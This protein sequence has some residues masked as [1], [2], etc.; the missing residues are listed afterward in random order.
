MSQRRQNTGRRRWYGYVGRRTIQSQT[1]GVDAARHRRR[2]DSHVN[3]NK[4]D[5]V[6]DLV[7]IYA[8]ASE[9]KMIPNVFTGQP[10]GGIA[11]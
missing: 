2:A 6:N 9:Q 1:N 11:N 10:F 3:C 7:N 8:S 4:L 5:N